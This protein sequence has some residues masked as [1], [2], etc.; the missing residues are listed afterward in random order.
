MAKKRA[1]NRQRAAREEDAVE[2]PQELEEAV[3]PIDGLPELTIKP[4]TI[5]MALFL[6]PTVGMLAVL[7]LYLGTVSPLVDAGTAT[8]LSL[9]RSLE[10]VR[11]TSVLV[12][13]LSLLVTGT[14]LIS[15]G[16]V[17]R[18]RI[19]DADEASREVEIAKARQRVITAGVFASFVGGVL[20]SIGLLV[21]IDPP[22]LPKAGLPQ[23]TMPKTLSP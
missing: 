9:P 1:T 21:K 7:L 19:V 12:G 20:L 2:D 10:L 4:T 6:V 8:E 23:P 18:P 16:L 14:M 22:T 3:D 17:S 15:V 13:G 11:V 5:V